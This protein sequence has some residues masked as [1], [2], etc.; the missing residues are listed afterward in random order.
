MEKNTKLILLIIGAG[1]LILGAVFLVTNI[2]KLLV[3]HW[4]TLIVLGLAGAGLLY[5]WSQ[6]KRNNAWTSKQVAIPG[7]VGIVLL[8]IFVIALFSVGW[9]ILWPALVALAGFGIILFVTGKKP[10]QIVDIVK[11]QFDGD[12]P[13]NPQPPAQQ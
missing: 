1:L 12:E 2:G 5:S 10:A 11:D 3:Y 9:M 8:I 7:G 4:W 6:W 13:P